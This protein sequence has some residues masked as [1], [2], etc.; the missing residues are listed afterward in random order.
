MLHIVACLCVIARRQGCFGFVLNFMLCYS[1]LF[2]VSY[3][4][5][6]IFFYF[7]PVQFWLCQLRKQSE[8]I[9][10]YSESHPFSSLFF[11]IISETF[12]TNLGSP[13]FS[14]RFLASSLI[15]FTSRMSP[16]H[17]SAELHHSTH[18]GTLSLNM[19]VPHFGQS[20]FSSSLHI[21]TSQPQLLH[22][23]SIGVGVAFL[24]L[25]GHLTLA[26]PFLLY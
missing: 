16:M 13:S 26:I 9:L 17:S 6:R 3:F 14:A 15:F 4:E 22:F 2:H 7:L 5:F 20:A 1:N 18:V 19:V 25:P 21:S 12:S 23:R 10:I 24:I 8:I 11:F